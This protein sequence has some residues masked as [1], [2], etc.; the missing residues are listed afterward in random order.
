MDTIVSIWS[1][2]LL[3]SVD[4]TAWLFAGVIVAAAIL[5]RL[6]KTFKQ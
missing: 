2:W 4:T 5:A 6:D 3:S 1:N